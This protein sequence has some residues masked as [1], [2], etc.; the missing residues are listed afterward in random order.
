MGQGFLSCT[1]TTEDGPEDKS[2]SVG[3]R[4]DL[5]YGDDIILLVLL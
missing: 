3:P 1:L 4:V 2:S 5:G